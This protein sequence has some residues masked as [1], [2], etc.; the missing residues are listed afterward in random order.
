MER[1]PLRTKPLPSVEDEV[2]RV[3]MAGEQAQHSAS[4]GLNQAADKASDAVDQ[5]KDQAGSVVQQATD[6]AKDL[7]Q[8]LRSKDPSEIA[9][10]LKDKASDLASQ[11]K[12]K[13]SDV[14]AQAADKADDAMS[15]TGQGM[16]T[17]AQTV[18]ENAPTGKVG[19]IATSAATAL[20]KGGTYLQQADPAAVRSDLEEIIRRNP[21]PSLLVGLGIGFLL[22]RSLRR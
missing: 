5:A 17:L 22:A 8:D 18:R 15:A 10:D 16:Q 4:S 9:S 6:K 14:T 7:V 3:L 13:A 1:D 12:D 19:D 11:A 20:E 2:H 21:V